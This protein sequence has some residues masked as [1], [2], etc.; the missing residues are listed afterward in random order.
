MALPVIPAARRE[1]ARRVITAWVLTT[2][3]AKIQTPKMVEYHI[4]LRDISQSKAA[5][6]R[7]SARA[8]VDTGAKRWAITVRFGSRELSW[9]VE[10][11]KYI[12]PMASQARK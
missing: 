6:V 9:R 3:P 8:K 12:K 2:A 5:K 7:V 1:S 11:R 10:L 4:G